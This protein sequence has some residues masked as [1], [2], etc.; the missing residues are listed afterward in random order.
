M[1]LAR[2]D[3]NGER[4][5]A[6]APVNSSVI[7]SI[8]YDADHAVLEVEFVSGQVYRYH[9]VPRR[10]WNELM[11]AES[12]GRYFDAHIRQRFPTARLP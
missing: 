10:I 5:I 4:S 12:K 2:P 1:R 9:F 11:L 7:R 6:R 8:G 3:A